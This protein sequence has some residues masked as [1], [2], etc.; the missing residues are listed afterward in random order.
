MLRPSLTHQLASSYSF[1]AQL[2]SPPWRL[3]KS[4]DKKALSLCSPQAP[5]HFSH[6]CG[7]CDYTAFPLLRL[8]LRRTVPY[9]MPSIWLR[10]RTLHIKWTVS[11]TKPSSLCE[12][13]HRRLASLYPE[14]LLTRIF[15]TIGVRVSSW[16]NFLRGTPAFPSIPRQQHLLWV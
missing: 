13:L 16:W 5:K 2:S 15:L 1:L 14:G 6:C 7:F 9:S 3:P 10:T 11:R 12:C 4:L 8:I